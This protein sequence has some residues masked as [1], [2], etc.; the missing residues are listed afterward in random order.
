MKKIV[1]LPAAVFLVSGLIFGRFIGRNFVDKFDD[2]DTRMNNGDRYA[3]PYIA[4]CDTIR[5]VMKDFKDVASY[6]KQVNLTPLRLTIPPIL[7]SSKWL[8]RTV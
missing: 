2:K 7:I 3:D 6:F 4:C 8:S 5:L 1:F